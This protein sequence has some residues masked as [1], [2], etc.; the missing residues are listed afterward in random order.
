MAVVVDAVITAETSNFDF[1]ARYDL[2]LLRM[3]VQAER[4]FPD[5]PTT[6]LIKLRQFGEVLAQ[7][8]AA[9]AGIFT[10]PEEPQADLL[11][12]LRLEVGYP[13]EVI[14]LFHDLRRAGNEAVHRHHGD[15]A[16]ALTCLKLARQ[17]GIWFHRTYGGD[18]N[19]RP[20]SFLPPRPP[21]DP[22]AALRQELDRL[23]AE[24]DASLSA[25]DRAREAAAAAEAAR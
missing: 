14:D 9:R 20:G 17:L 5:D 8:V 19:F 3:A 16:T 10:S 18:R 24:R 1:L 13:G 7:Q 22:T 25:A 12:R 4:Y 15:H 11:R 21:A 2:V 6:S 23:M